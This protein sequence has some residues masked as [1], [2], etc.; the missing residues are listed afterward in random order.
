MSAQ[1]G[2][3][4]FVESTWYR[5]AEM[6]LTK[7]RISYSNRGKKRKFWRR[8]RGINVRN[9]RAVLKFPCKLSRE[10]SLNNALYSFVYLEG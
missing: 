2:P 1:R 4:L 5:N 6:L 9:P 10:A 7:K 3:L 8:F